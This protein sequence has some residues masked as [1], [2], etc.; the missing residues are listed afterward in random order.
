MLLRWVMLENWKNKFWC[1]LG[2]TIY[3]FQEISALYFIS[4]LL[5]LFGRTLFGGTVPVLFVV[6][7]WK[8][9][10]IEHLYI[11]AENPVTMFI[12]FFLLLFTLVAC[13]LKPAMLAM[14]S[15]ISGAF[16]NY[17]CGR[18]LGTHLSSPG[19]RPELTCVLAWALL[20]L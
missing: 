15:H 8:S 13:L 1:I 2:L 11:F 18:Q 4:S 12:S 16:C 3:S 7:P 5:F 9:L 20:A 19:C 17:Q 6:Y 14:I 10:R